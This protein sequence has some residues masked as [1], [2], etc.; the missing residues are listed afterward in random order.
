MG[1]WAAQ[2]KPRRM[3]ASA[4]Q[5]APGMVPW[6]EE[7]PDRH[8]DPRRHET[9]DPTRMRPKRNT[10]AP[11]SRP[12]AIIA[13]APAGPWRTPERIAIAIAFA[14]VI[15]SVTFQ[16][17]EYDFWQ[18]LTFGK[19]LWLSH[20]IPMTQ[21]W[22][23]PDH[24]VPVDNPSWGFS[25]LIWPFWVF[26]GTSGLVVWRWLSV[27]TVFVFLWKSARALGV[28]SVVPLVVLVLC[29]LVYRQRS[30]VR[31]ET[32]AAMLLAFEIWLLT[33]R[34]GPGWRDLALVATA[35]VWA[36]VH[37]SWYLG[38]AVLLL[39]TFAPRF[40]GD[41]ASRA[42]AAG[43]ER[44]VLAALAVSFVNPFGWR[45]LWRPFAFALFGRHDPL[46]SGI[47]ELQPLDW[48]ANWSNGLPLLMAGW[49]A[50][51]IWRWRR[52]GR[53]PVELG[54]ALLA[55]TLAFLGT[56][57]VATY[58]VLAAPWI[59]RDFDDW[60][61]ARRAVPTAASAWPAALVTSALCIVLPLYEW[62]HF[63]HKLGFGFDAARY[64][65]AACDFMEQHEVR[66]HGINDF[67]LGGYLLWRFWPDST[68]LPFIDIH[69]EDKAAPVRLAYQK[70]FT[71]ASGWAALDGQY[72]FDYALLSRSYLRTYGLLDLLDM[73][74]DWALVFV[75]DVAA[76]YVKRIGA[77][78]LLA[79]TQGYAILSGGRMKQERVALEITQDPTL[80]TGLAR[81]LER[82]AGSSPW[83]RTM[84]PLR[85][86][87]AASGVAVPAPASAAAGA[88]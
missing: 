19:A 65:V 55:T 6:L 40:G 11:A 25:A 3:V 70:A 1:P 10:P 60:W 83:S 58:A 5:T 8:P 27:I 52:A 71:S 54:T 22:T 67:Y 56:R 61:R 38:L 34:R 66:G 18:H 81:E 57:F 23:W 2:V 43:L 41:P 35:L 69:P 24:G 20:R 26:G 53:D 7:R 9:G 64:P 16:M 36:N 31:P 87:C 85:E 62:Q 82:Q 28:R 68:R 30:Q 48:R 32:L 17:Y 73:H 47:S 79:D 77:L 84:A 14:V 46:L 44:V 21:L 78:G 59:A 86:L 37:L 80:A 45:T 50:L 12:R 74:P 29:A 72:R 51:L 13:S 4:S 63:E 33:T 42:R 49:P 75:D 39:H 15:V 88:H 76:L